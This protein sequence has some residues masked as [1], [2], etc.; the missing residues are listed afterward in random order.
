M[1]TNRLNLNSFWNTKLVYYQNLKRNEVEMIELHHLQ[2]P[3]SV[4]YLSAFR[5]NSLDGTL[6]INTQYTDRIEK[7]LE[8]NKVLYFQFFSI[9]IN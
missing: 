5:I 6:S 4:F 7:G 9:E 3:Y 2:H 1:K 8:S